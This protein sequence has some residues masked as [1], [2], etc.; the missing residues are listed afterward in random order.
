MSDEVII[1]DSE[2]ESNAATAHS[3]AAGTGNVKNAFA[4]MAG[5]AGAGVAAPAAPP[6]KRP[7]LSER[8]K[9]I[10]R[11]NNTIMH[12][13][14]VLASEDA[15]AA[16]VNK[17]VESD[18]KLGTVICTWCTAPGAVGM[19]VAVGENTGNLSKHEDRSDHKKVRRHAQGA[20]CSAA[21][22]RPT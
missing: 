11:W 19:E 16:Y 20:S 5:G 15:M 12:T 8:D 6:T 22:R 17:C 1:D 13:P 7:R 18:G 4:L 14:Y 9:A 21:R 10:G 2:D 3:A